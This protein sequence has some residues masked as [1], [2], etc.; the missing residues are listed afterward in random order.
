MIN[1]SI[2]NDCYYCSDFLENRILKQNR[3]LLLVVK[4]DIGAGFINDDWYEE[5]KV[6]FKYFVESDIKN[7]FASNNFRLYF[8]DTWKYY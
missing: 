8:L 3:K 7:Y 6:Y 1:I 5:N 4:K 2:G